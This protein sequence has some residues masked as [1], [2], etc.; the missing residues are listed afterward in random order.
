[1]REIG[2]SPQPAEKDLPIIAC[3]TGHETTC[4][5]PSPSHDAASRAEG[6]L[7]PIAVESVTTGVFGGRITYDFSKRIGIAV[8]AR[9]LP[10]NPLVLSAGL[11]FRF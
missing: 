7:E 2:G 8:D 4:A 9:Y 6:R 10:L 3:P 5:A 1:M 11:R